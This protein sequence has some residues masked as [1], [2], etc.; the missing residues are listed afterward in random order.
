MYLVSY[1]P[2]KD[3]WLIDDYDV[4]EYGA[5]YH[6]DSVFLYHKGL[7]ADSKSLVNTAWRRKLCISAPCAFW[8]RTWRKHKSLEEVLAKLKELGLQLNQGDEV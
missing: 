5:E 7:I 8:E 4:K 3:M 1:S 6:R 2:E